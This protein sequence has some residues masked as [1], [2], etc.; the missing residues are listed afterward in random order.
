MAMFNSYVKL[1]EGNWLL[2]FTQSIMETSSV[3]LES[4]RSIMFFHVFS[5]WCSSQ[6]SARF[7]STGQWKMFFSISR[8]GPKASSM[9]GSGRPTASKDIWDPQS[10]WRVT[11]VDDMDKKHPSIQ[12]GTSE[13]GNLRGNSSSRCHSWIS[14][15]NFGGK[16]KSK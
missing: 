6:K 4:I 10:T 9:A 11:N 14:M 8:Q 15:W 16:P 5:V 1:P 3:D 2:M 13:L 7:F 12:D